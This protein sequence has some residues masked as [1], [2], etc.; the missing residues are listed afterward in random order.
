MKLK[1]IFNSGKMNKD[2]DERLVPKGQYRDALNVRVSGSS[3]SDVGAIENSPSNEGLTQLDF[4]NNPISI[5]SVSDDA[6]KKIYWFV[7]SDSGSFICEYDVDNDASTF[8]LKDTR[9]WK[10][11]VL[12]FYKTNFIEANI[13]IDIDNDKRFLFFTDGINPP[14]RIEIE[15]SK[16]VDAN[17]FT[18]YDI[19]VIQQPPLEAPILSL[20]TSSTNE[21]NIKERFLY[22]AY[23]YKYKHGEYS[24]LSPFSEVA[25]LPGNFSFDFATGLNKSMVNAYSQV[26]ITFNTGTSNVVEIDLIFKESNSSNVYVAQTFNKQDESIG[27][28]TTK[29]HSF[30][31]SKVYSVLSEKELLRVY[32]NVPLTA[33]TQ[34]LIGNRIVYANYTENFDLKDANGDSIPFNINATLN[35]TDIASPSVAKSIKSNVDYEVGIVYLDDYGRSTSV[36][37]SENATVNVPLSASKTKNEISI[38]VNHLPPAFAKY[39]RLYVKQS[40][41]KYETINPSIFYNEAE[42]GYTYIQLNGNDKNK[43]QEGDFLIVKADTRGQK[44]NLVE[45]QVLEIKTQNKNFLEADDYPEE[46]DPPIAQESGL[47]MKIKPVGFSI[48]TN[49]YEKTEH[50]DYDDTASDRDDPLK[51]SQTVGSYIEGPFAYSGS[52]GSALPTDVTITGTYT[53]SNIFSRII[54]EIDAVNAGG[55]TF[56]TTVQTLDNDPNTGSTTTGQAITSG[57]PIA[58]PGTGLSVDFA[59]NTGHTIGDKWTINA[60]PSTF[61]YTPNT[62]AF[63]TYRSFDQD[64]E[65]IPLGT[66]IDLVY[67]E[68][69]EETQYVAHQF[70]AGADYA[71]IEEWYHESG[72]KATLNADIPEDRIFF[73]RGTFAAKEST[74]TNST[75]DNI[76]MIIRSLGTKNNPLDKRPKIDTLITFLK[77]QSSDII[78]LE[79]RPEDR[80]DEVFYEIPGTYDITQGY[81]Q[82][83]PVGAGLVP[84]DTSILTI[85]NTNL[86]TANTVGYVNT[87]NYPDSD[88]WNN[89][90]SLS[91][92][93]FTSTG[94][95]IQMA[96]DT[97]SYT[98]FA[99]YFTGGSGPNN[100]GFGNGNGKEIRLSQG[101]ATLTIAVQYFQRYDVT[102]GTRVVFFNNSPSALP[103]DS[104]NYVSG[105]GSFS[106]SGGDFTAVFGDDVD[107]SQTHNSPANITLDFFNVFSWGNCVE[108]YKI[109]D[110]FNTKFFQL[111][112]RP[113]TNLK[114]YKKNHRTASITYSNVYDQTTKYN[115]L[116]E[117]NLAFANYKDMDDFFGDI[118]KIVAREADL[119]VFQENKVS[120]LLF[121][122]NVLFNADGSSNITASTAILGQDIPYLGEYGI[123]RNPFA[124]V[125]WG[126]RIYFVDERRRV[127]CRLSQDGITQISDFGMIDW[128]NDN[129]SSSLPPLAIGQYDP[130]DRQYSLSLKGTQ[131]E[132]REDEVECE[133]LYDNTDTDGDGTV[134][135]IDTDDDGD[136][137]LDV[138]DAFPLDATES[139][140]TDGDGIGNNSDTD[141]DGDG[142][143]DATDS[144][145]LD[146]QEEI[147]LD[148]DGDGILDIHDPDDDNDGIPDTQ[149][150]GG[151][152]TSSTNADTDGDGVDDSEDQFPNDPTE[153]VDTDGDGTGDN[154]DTDDD[155]DGTPDSTD[156]FP[157]DPNETTDT[158]GDGVG[159]N[160]D[161]D[162]DNDGVADVD[163]PDNDGDGIPDDTDPDDDNDGTPDS[164]DDDPTDSSIQTDTDDDGIDDSID[165]DDDG[166]GVPDTTDAFPL[167]PAESVDTDGDGTGDNADTDDDDDGTPDTSD[168]FPLDPN[169]TTDTDGDGTGDNTD[170]DDDGDG[171]SDTDDFFPLDPN[172]SRDTD[173]DGT[174][175]NEDTDDDNDGTPDSSDSFPTDPENQTNNPADTDS[176]TVIDYYDTD[177]DGDGFSDADETTA[178]SDPLDSTDTP[179][180]TDGDGTPDISD[181]DDDGDGISDADEIALGTDPLDA[182]DTPT[183]TDG[184]GTPDATDTDD[185]NDGVPDSQDPFPLDATRDAQA[186]FSISINN[187]SK[188]DHTVP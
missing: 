99:N 38:S 149:E 135:S 156:A 141:D 22:F 40:K 142:I 61:L 34:Q 17:A 108:S 59:S 65:E 102:G 154:A 185:D 18:K 104:I 133:I 49:D 67:D 107:V 53:T 31:N 43:I 13:L 127:V 105:S 60:R 137:V 78:T 33:E 12:N 186:T 98:A 169:E 113:S 41:G 16:L 50:D 106:N 44:T 144:D 128:F 130:R 6:N 45:T 11:N 25:F 103:M 180:D 134:D 150:T 35:T 116:N 90:P 81:H 126:G 110:D 28:N 153:T 88:N 146:P 73:L 162:D 160:A 131:V 30:S 132:W 86:S 46:D 114:D 24:A 184:D 37:T 178:G 164:E 182:N 157:Q 96:F 123:T 148:T 122:K 129:L 68:F 152:S 47:Y 94:Y 187:N 7:R 118:N 171:V 188:V 51:N 39:Y 8:V 155:N 76:L 140:D 145:P 69:N 56:T 27:D 66:I 167:N 89:F 32:D 151:S 176:D 183:D 42:T 52:G 181:T 71:N 36:I 109:K 120:K 14:R 174:G 9:S 57:I 23:R 5:G 115:G 1:N 83:G 161:P 62:K 159:D 15:T 147:T 72:A 75:S 93:P 166:D 84:Q 177:D 168:A 125:L 19:D 80:N 143:P 95:K 85:A 77:R 136:G 119:V 101:S 55:D 179:P 139:V 158:D 170:T 64:V 175:D 79:T 165:T 4:G 117:F 3:A 74:I 48:S 163:E 92:N 2:L 29:V 138:N 112:N 54:I 97:N 172:E 10:T 70:T 111:E 124:T 91:S 26:D 21:N 173:G 121:N 82:S 100:G 20:G 58:I 63:A 87:S